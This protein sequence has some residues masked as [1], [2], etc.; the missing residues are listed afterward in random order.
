MKRLLVSLD[1]HRDVLVSFPAELGLH[2]EGARRIMHGHEH[3]H[4]LNL[5]GLGELLVV[6]QIRQLCLCLDGVGLARL[7]FDTAE[8]RE[9]GGPIPKRVRSESRQ[10][11][12]QRDTYQFV[13]SLYFLFSPCRK[14]SMVYPLL[15][16]RKMMGLTP[17]RIMTDSSCTV[18]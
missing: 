12:D 18:S 6:E 8:R 3:L 1:A 5:I 9:K 13:M 17:M 15:L 14:R 7:A 10:S 4:E 11:E 16:S 2:A